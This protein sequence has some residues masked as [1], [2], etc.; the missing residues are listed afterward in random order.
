MNIIAKNQ[1]GNILITALLVLLVINLL[2]IG[3]MQ[4]ALRMSKSATFKT[5]DSEVFHVTDSCNDDV[6]N[7]LKAQTTAPTTLP[8]FTTANLNYMLTGS[9][10]TEMLNKLSGYNYGCTLTVLSS[11]SSDT[12]TTANTGEEVGSS[13]GYGS[14]GDLSQKTYYKVTSTGGGPKNSVKIIN[15]IISAEY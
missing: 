7:W 4:V 15:T 11:Q 1:Q 12:S 5:I 8:N 14:A 3:V 2:A 6:I 10:T 13:S 9:E